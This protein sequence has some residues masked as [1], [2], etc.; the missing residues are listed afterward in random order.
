MQLPI[1]AQYKPW[2]YLSPFLRYNVQFSYNS[3]Y[4]SSRSAKVDDFHLIWRDICHF[5]L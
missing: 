4:W 1:N 3:V 2:P 5:I